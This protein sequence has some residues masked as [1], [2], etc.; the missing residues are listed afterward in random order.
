MNYR[1][2][3]QFKLANYIRYTYKTK[4]DDLSNIIK[5]H[6]L[7]HHQGS[8]P[9]NFIKTLPYYKQAYHALQMLRINNI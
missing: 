8:L 1:Q 2:I 7:Y 6:D 9:K 4:A 5:K 3:R